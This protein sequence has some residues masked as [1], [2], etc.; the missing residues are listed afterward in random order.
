MPKVSIIM[1]AY[2]AGEYISLA[3]ESILSQ[4]FKEWELVI[5]DDCSTDN[6]VEIVESFCKEHENIRL[7][8]RSMN[9]G[10]AR[11]PRRE[12][13]YATRSEFIMTYDADDFLDKDYMEKMYNRQ[14][15]TGANIVLS[16]LHFCNE[17]GELNGYVIPSA[18]FPLDSTMNGKEATMFLLGEVS[19]SVSG[20]LVERQRYLDNISS[21]ESEEDNYSYVDE[22]DQRRLLFNCEKIAFADTKYYYRQHSES[23]MHKKDIKRYNY[24]QTSKCI[25]EFAKRNYTEGSLFIKL[26]KDYIQ[27]LI[28]CQRDYYYYKHYRTNYAKEAMEILKDSFK[29]AKEEKMHP[30]GL[31][32]KVCMISNRTFRIISSLYALFLNIRAK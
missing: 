19:I 16:T 12:S 1:P 26:Q 6:T 22:I 2:N 32:Q 30:Q 4:T 24:L 28:F 3:I 14:K 13:A 20:L 5:T 9:S 15:E 31:K 29:Y 11:L 10:A 27:S 25:Y 8:R 17:K 21:G 7:I 23:L 18:S